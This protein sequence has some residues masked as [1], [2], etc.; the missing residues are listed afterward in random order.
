MKKA[1]FHHLVDILTLNRNQFWG[2]NTPQTENESMV[3]DLC[4][5]VCVSERERVCV[6]VCVIY[7]FNNCKNIKKK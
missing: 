4:V 7:V 1:M 2:F 5:C 6:L 3:D